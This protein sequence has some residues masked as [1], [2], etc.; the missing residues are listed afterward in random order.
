MRE[1]EHKAAEATLENI[2]AGKSQLKIDGDDAFKQ[3]TAQALGRLMS[4]PTGRALVTD[5]SGAPN[6]TTIQKS[7]SGNTENAKNW[8]DG[9]F[10]RAKKTAGPGTSTTVDFNPKR[11]KLNGENWMERDPAI[12][13]GHEL[14][15]AHHDVHGTTDGR[16]S[17][18][19]TDADGKKRK[20][21]GYELQ[22]VGLGEYE[23]NR[24]TENRLRDEHDNGVSTLNRDEASRPHY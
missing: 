7:T 17:V 13:L 4:R 19:Y 3:D 1:S 23:D 8:N 11:S 22:T 16:R 15:H 9:L 6:E 18:T 21:P 24:F 20:A 14:I 12:G 5:L 2:Q 10:D